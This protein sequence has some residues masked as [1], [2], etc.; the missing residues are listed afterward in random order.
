MTQAFCLA[1]VLV[2]AASCG[3]SKLPPPVAASV[4]VS[5]ASTGV[6]LAPGF[7]GFSYEKS[8]LTGA[9]FDARHTGLVAL[10]QRLGPG[11][12]RVG[13]NTVDKTPWNGTG[14]GLKAGEIG[15]P[16]VDR[17]AGFLRAADWKVLYG[18]DLG[19]GTSASFASEAAYAAAALG[20][21]LAGFEIG[22]EPDIYH[23]NG[24]RPATWTYADYK[25]E[26]EA[27]AAAVRGAVPGA[28]LTGPAAAYDAK[29]FTI[30]FAADE[31]ALVSLLT[32]HYYRAN[33]QLATST[34]DLLLAGDPA[35]PTSLQAL[36]S[37]AQG[38]GIAGG[39]RLAECNSY[40]NGG[41]PNVSDAFGSALW[42]VDFLFTLAQNGAAGANL[43][44]GGRGPG[45]TPLADDG[46][47]VVEVRPE[48]YGIALFTSA[49][50]GALLTAQAASGDLPLSA[51]AVARPDGAT[52][53]VLVNRDRSRDA[54][55]TADLGTAATSAT[56]TRLTG[57]SLDDPTGQLLQGATIGAD[58][59]FAPAAPPEVP[60]AGRVVRLTVPAG[61]AALVLAR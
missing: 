48:Y 2:L 16:D 11:L 26:W 36:R 50:D 13:G 34:V 32:Q 9:L 12:L 10:F 44:G 58:G 27:A 15:P 38:A 37:A 49:A 52:A 35:L 7:A 31:K 1:L 25:V 56:V 14:T 29:R 24:L 19:G 45:Y 3:R 17:L 59:S 28:A 53:L 55:V 23:S 22:N 21:R 20:D 18:L 33:G 30:P 40:Y 43:H 5:R 60:V 8:K 51:W 46:T 61:S 39:Y 41:A 4:T 57:T 42:V 47:N 54:D 6:T